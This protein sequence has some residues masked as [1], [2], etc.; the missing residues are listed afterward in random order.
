MRACLLMLLISAGIAAAGCASST[1]KTPSSPAVA[2]TDANSSGDAVI[3]ELE[4]E[5][6]QKQASVAD[7]LEPVNR[8][9][10]GFND[11][12]YFWVVKPVTHV[13]TG[14]TPRPVRISIGNFFHHIETPGRFVNC[15]LQGKGPAADAELHRFVVNTFE[16][17]LG[18]GD[19]ARDKW[20]IQRVDEDLGQTLAMYGIGNG[21]Y[22][23]WPLYGP[24]TLRDS[25]GTLGDQCMNPVRY[26]EPEEAS[27]GISVVSVVNQR[28]FHQGEYEALKSASVDPYVA[29]RTAYVQYRQKQALDQ[30]ESDEPADPN[31]V[32]P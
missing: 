17:V 31:G 28:S 16:G 21:V 29:M 4:E 8:F 22:L 2:A 27:I 13:Y 26:V 7:P 5:Y 25:L 32:K 30:D 9:M 23:V 6:S 19:P 14:V 1:K 24:S 12:L 10:Y 15:L 11:V 20:H 3:D 18:F